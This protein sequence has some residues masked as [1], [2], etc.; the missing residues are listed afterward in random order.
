MG[1]K[2]IMWLAL[3]GVGALVFIGGYVLFRP[4]G[5]PSSSPG[6]S[7]PSSYSVPPTAPSATRPATPPSTSPEKTATSTVTYRNGVFSPSTIT[8]NAGEAIVFQNENSSSL[9][10]VS[11]PH[12]V[13]SDLPGFDARRG[14]SQGETY[15]F[16]F[17]QKGAFGYHNHLNPGARG[18][19]VV[20]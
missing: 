6:Y 2:N 13:H 10:V 12:P 15:S 4:L 16:T 5:Q 1:Q 11:D 19:I 20:E 7:S 18:T 9:W 3:A 17:T 14:M 8:I